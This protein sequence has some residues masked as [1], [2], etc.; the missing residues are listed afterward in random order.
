MH[1]EGNDIRI[2]IEEAENVIKLK[3]D[4]AKLV[5]GKLFTDVVG[6]AYFEQESI[7][8]VSLMGDDA[9]DDTV[10]VEIQKMMYGIAYFQRWLRLKILEGQEMESYVK[11]ANAELDMVDESE[12]N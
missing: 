6:K 4:V 8:L 11:D 10:K 2:S 1:N 12:V 3:N 9:L 5:G 7:R